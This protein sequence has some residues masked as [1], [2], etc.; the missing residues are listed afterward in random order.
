MDVDDITRTDQARVV[1][2]SRLKIEWIKGPQG[3]AA[4]MT[5]VA[6]DHIEQQS[7]ARPHR[8]VFECVAARRPD[9]PGQ[10]VAM[11]KTPD[12]EDRL[13]VVVESVRFAKP[14]RAEGLALLASRTTGIA[15]VVIL[16]TQVIEISSE[17]KRRAERSSRAIDAPE[18]LAG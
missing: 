16:E 9:R 3:A 14:P 2:I 6:A 15:G 4:V 13:D 5:G 10:N 17:G 12:L 18:K 1:E 8:G 11:R 7:Q